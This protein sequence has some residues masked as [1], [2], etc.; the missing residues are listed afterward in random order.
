MRKIVIGEVAMQG[1]GQLKWAV[2]D[3]IRSLLSFKA[4]CT[5]LN[6]QF[7]LNYL[8]LTV[9]DITEGKDDYVA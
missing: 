4:Y 6:W 3:N 5:I 9:C 1:P 8:V 2:A 7:H